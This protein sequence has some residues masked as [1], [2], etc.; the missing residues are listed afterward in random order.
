MSSLHTE[1]CNFQYSEVLL[2][3]HSYEKQVIYRKMALP[4]IMTSCDM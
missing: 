3:N 2:G 1:E 4:T